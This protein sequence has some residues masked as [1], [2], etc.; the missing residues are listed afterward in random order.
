MR[1]LQDGILII[2]ILIGFSVSQLITAAIQQYY[3]TSW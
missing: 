1:Y 2:D 3:S